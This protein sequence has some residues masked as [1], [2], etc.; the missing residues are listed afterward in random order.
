MERRKEKG[1]L[2][3]NKS[4]FRSYKVYSNENMLIRGNKNKI[5]YSYLYPRR[6]Q[7]EI[8]PH[9]IAHITA[10][11]IFCKKFYA[12]SYG[13]VHR[14]ESVQQPHCEFNARLES[15]TLITL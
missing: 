13:W 11:N 5:Y 9:N 3:T 1:V 15:V 8:L 7:C 12:T 14:E 10:K 6:P 4:K 2:S